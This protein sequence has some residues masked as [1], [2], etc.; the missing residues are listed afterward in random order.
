MNA[1]M[2]AVVTALTAGLVAVT[3]AVLPGSATDAADYSTAVNT[4]VRD[5]MYPAYGSTVVD[6]LHYGLDL[7]WQPQT[8]VLTGKEALT[9]RAARSAPSFSLDLAGRLHASDVL[10]DG[11]RVQV[12]HTGHKLQIHHA[13]T[14]GSR[15]VLRL[16]YRGVPHQVLLDTTRSGVMPLGWMTTSSG[17]A[18]AL[19]EPFGAFT[20]Y[21]VN[22]QPSDKAMYDFRIAAPQKW[23]GVANGTLLSRTVRNGQTIT[24]WHLGVPAS[25]YLTTIGIG[26]YKQTID[27]TIAGL[28]I[29]YWT[30]RS[31][32]WTL[33]R[34][35]YTPTAVKW[36]EKRLGAYPF[37]SLGILVAPEGGMETETMVTM[38]RD[39]YTLSR[40]VI[41]HELAH[42][43]FGDEVSPKR[44]S[45]GWLNE[46]WATYMAEATWSAHGSASALDSILTDWNDNAARLRRRGG[47]PAHPHTSS[48]FDGNIYYIPALM[49]DLVRQQVGD[50]TFWKLAAAW[51]RE[52]RF[53]SAD[54][55]TAVRWWSDKTGIDLVPLFH[56]WLLAKEQPS[57]S[58][59]TPPPAGRR[60]ASALSSRLPG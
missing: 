8:R 3:V 12:S 22:D 4:P 1:G 59:A 18:Y 60:V 44:W 21:A 33:A 23:V 17:E 6:A 49:W 19:Q 41:V 14:A 39:S 45:D 9:F 29:T 24:R 42:Q 28:P 30:P 56:S 26:P 43:W 31:S 58:P 5:D 53:G 35:R 16:R 27:H 13:V 34:L 32:P 57:W 38:G 36:L 46:G 47:P 7:R 2:R 15:H 54:Y 10:L 52:H 20:W 51:P 50:A 40:D 37:P 25:S 55:D 48:A 11:H